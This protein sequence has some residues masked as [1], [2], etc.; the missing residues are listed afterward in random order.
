MWRFGEYPFLPFIVERDSARY[1]ESA[2]EA[3][4]REHRLDDG[5][6][7]VE[8]VSYRNPIKVTL[9]LGISPKAALEI[10]RDW[11]ARRRMNNAIADDYED[12]V[13]TRKRIRQ[14]LAERL[15]EGEQPVSSNLIENLLSTD[16]VE[17]F[18]TL[19]NSSVKL[20]EL[21]PPRNDGSG[22]EV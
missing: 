15:L 8:A 4:A 11:S 5:S 13:R 16:V 1:L 17:A 18:R 2:V 9:S 22:N 20:R 21:E 3:Y 14:E 7:L 19:G 10:L 12:I 6:V